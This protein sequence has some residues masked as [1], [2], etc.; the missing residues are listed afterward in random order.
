[1]IH[2]WI[3]NGYIIQVN[4]TSILGM[5]GS[6]NKRNAKILLKN[7]YVHVVA[8]DAHRVSSNRVCKLSDVYEYICSKF[9]KQNA[10]LLCYKNPMHIIHNEFVECMEK[11][12]GLLERI[13]GGGVKK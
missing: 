12:Q 13:F 1:M 4:R 11:K 2:K 9:G 5:H 3:S 6:M 7:G 8:S 10:D